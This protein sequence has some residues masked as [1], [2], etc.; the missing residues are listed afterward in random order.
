MGLFSPLFRMLGFKE[1]NVRIL[2]VGLDNSGKTTLVNHIKPKKA[3]A[4]FEVTPTVGYQVEEFTKHNLSFTVLDMSGASRYRSLW[5]SSYETASAIMFVMDS[6]DKIRM[7]VAR[8]EL[9][10]LLMSPKLQ[11]KA[12][13]ILF[14]ANKMDVPGSLTPVDCMKVMA[15]ERI[16]NKPWHITSSNALT[17]AGVDDGVEWL[18]GKLM[19][20]GDDDG[21]GKYGH[22]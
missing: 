11:A 22:K 1:K 13:P 8:D 7:C 3:Q 9:D 17:G 10:E 15:L 6:T 4:T 14:F 12:I 16:T 5:E 20:S 19:E 21:G 2:V 18:A